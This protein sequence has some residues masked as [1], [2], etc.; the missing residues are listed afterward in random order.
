[1]LK[2]V[3]GDFSNALVTGDITN[4]MKFFSGNAQ[5]LYGPVL[6]QIAPSLPAAVAN[7]EPPQ[8]GALANNVAE[9]SVR[10]TIEGVKRLYFIYFLLDPN[11]IWQLDSM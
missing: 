8:T 1:M 3:L 6:A 4:A 5:V 11:G 9:Y 10:R 7:W 2:A